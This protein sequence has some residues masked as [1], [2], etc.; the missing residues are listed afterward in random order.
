MAPTTLTPASLYVRLSKEAGESN[1]SRDGML[2]DLRTLAEGEGCEVV[3]EHVDD[4]ISGAVRDR[5]EFLA[6]LDD[7]RTGRAERLFAYH[8]D[9]L[10]REGVNAAALVLDVVE[11][12]DPETGRVVRPPVRLTTADGL[13]SDDADGFRWR[14]VIAAEVARAERA[15]IQARNS[16]AQ[17]RLR[18]AGRF[19]G[20]SAPYGYRVVPSPDGPGKALDVDPEEARWVRRAA[21]LVLEGASLYSVVQ[22]LREEGSTPRRAT[23]WSL[24]SLRAVLTGEAVLGRATH[25]GAVV[26]GPDGLPETRWPP[27]LPEADALRLRALLAP[28]GSGPGTQRRRRAARL[29]SGL[30]RCGSC[31]GPMRVNVSN[32]RVRYVCRAR[33][34]DT[35]RVCPR[36]VTITADLVDRHVEDEFLRRFGRLAE[37]RPVE[38]VQEVSEVAQVE[39]ALREVSAQ[40]IE[41]GADVLALSEQ[42]QALHARRAE[43]AAL[44]TTPR[45]ELLETGRTVREAWAASDVLGQRD[46]LLQVLAEPLIEVAPGVQRRKGLDPARL[47]IPWPFGP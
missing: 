23:A 46:L 15:R 1:T 22:T 38:S 24:P 2:R 36:P 10:T 44:P 16:A 3:A 28:S 45:L 26:R 8:A 31:H 43:L 7:A 6:W 25:R 12:K 21:D 18:E 9:R 42:I 4:G 19:R 27:L 13:D 34:G 11:G 33:A 37:I 32:G 39:A 41:P 40:M 20:G 35:G 17:R 29:L 47:S 30:L 5:P 14:F